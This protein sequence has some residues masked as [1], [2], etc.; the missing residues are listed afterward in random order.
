MNG[1][2][3]EHMK[4]KRTPPEK[5]YQSPTI[6]LLRWHKPLADLNDLFEYNAN[7]NMIIKGE[8][9]TLTHPSDLK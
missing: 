8:G 5:K 7:T 9:T 1:G 2:N 4:H 3:K 6:N